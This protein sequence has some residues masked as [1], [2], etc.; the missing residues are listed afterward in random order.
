VLEQFRRAFLMVTLKGRDMLLSK[1]FTAEE[2][3]LMI[4]M[5]EDPEGRVAADDTL[6]E[7]S[8]PCC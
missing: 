7:T 1:Y 8:S 5:P 2:L 4:K 3:V 6:R